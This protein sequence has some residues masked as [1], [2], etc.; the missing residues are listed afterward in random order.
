MKGNKNK[1]GNTDRIGN[2]GRIGKIG[3]QFKKVKGR[4]EFFDAVKEYIQTQKEVDELKLNAYFQYTTGASSML[5]KQ[6]LAVLESLD[7]IECIENPDPPFDRRF[8]I[9]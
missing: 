6:A 1:I 8:R 7:L 2:T 4:R 5:I 9:K 3:L